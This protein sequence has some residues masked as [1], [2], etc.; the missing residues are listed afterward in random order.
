MAAA[1]AG[2]TVAL[3]AWWQWAV[4]RGGRLV[5]P[6][7]PTDF[8]RHPEESVRVQ[9]AA[10]GDLWVQWSADAGRVTLHAGDNPETI[11]WQT[12]LLVAEN[13][14]QAA[15]NGRDGGQREYFGLQFADGRRQVVAERTLPLA[16]NGNFRDLG[17][18]PAA[19]GRTTR[20]GRAFR[21][22]TLA[23]LTAEDLTYLAEMN[24]RLVCDLRSPAEMERDP[25]RIP[26]GVAYQQFSIVNKNPIA[27]A[28]QAI[29][30]NRHQLGALMQDGYYRLIDDG[31]EQYGRLLAL[32]AD[33]GN[34]PLVFHCAAGKDRA[35]VAAALILRLLGVSDEIVLADYSLS[36]L[37]FDDLTG[38]FADEM[39]PF[40][41]LGVPFEQLHYPLMADPA[42]LAAIL[43]HIDR[44]YGGTEAYLTGPAGLTPAEVAAIRQNLLV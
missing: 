23:R 44:Q 3:V 36:N 41:R 16:G 24:L 25:D 13:G 42:W 37:I 39:A 22:S 27:Q 8:I 40:T 11:A 14:R 30:F 1:L 4:R 35:G 15:L 34:F 31:A 10:N 18:Y 32:L 20:W 19:N 21:S 38:E 28:V 7:S 2:A 43:D 5:R 9:R 26:A 29:L 33:E 12:P 17:G 6:V